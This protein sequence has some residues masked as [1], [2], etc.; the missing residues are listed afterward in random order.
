MTPEEHAVAIV[1]SW[2]GR[3][4]HRRL[5][6]NLPLLRE[7][8]EAE[9][10]EAVRGA[11]RDLVACTDEKIARAISA[12]E[13]SAAQKGGALA[14]FLALRDVAGAGDPA[15]AAELI[16]QKTEWAEPPRPAVPVLQIVEEIASPS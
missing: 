6:E 2:L 15:F 11:V 4:E 9:I 5:A 12:G 16:A 3:I 10:C 13:M 1:E 14:V 8:A 7:I